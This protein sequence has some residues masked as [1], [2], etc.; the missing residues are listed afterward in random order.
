MLRLRQAWSVSYVRDSEH[1]NSVVV[2]TVWTFYYSSINKLQY[3]LAGTLGNYFSI[4]ILISHVISNIIEKKM[5]LPG[6]MFF[7]VGYGLILWCLT[8]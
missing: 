1:N 5:F 8:D 4:F 6:L 7:V 3:F 2:F